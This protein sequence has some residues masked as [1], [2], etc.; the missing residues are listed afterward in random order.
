VTYSGGAGSTA[1]GFTAAVSYNGGYPPIFGSLFHS[2]NIWSFSNAVTATTQYTYS[3]ILLMLDTS[4]SMLIG[5]TSSDVT[6]LD[7]YSVCMKTGYLANSSGLNPLNFGGLGVIYEYQA[8]DNDQVDFT[9]VANYVDP[10]GTASDTSGTCAAGYRDTN[11]VVGGQTYSGAPLVP[12]ALACHT[13]TAKAADGYYADLYGNA[14][15]L[16]ATLRLDVVFSATEQVIND[17]ISATQIAGH[18]SVGVYQ[19]NADVAAIAKG[20]GGDPLPEATTNLQTALSEVQADDYNK[21]PGETAIPVLIGSIYTGVT[22]Q[23]VNDGNTNLALSLT[24]WLNGNASG[25]AAISASGSGITAATPKKFMFLV[26]DGLEDS[27]PG[28]LGGVNGQRVMGEMTGVLAESA[29]TGVC[30]QLKSLGFTVYV[31]YVPYTPVPHITF[32]T[33]AYDPQTDPYT[34]TDYPAVTNG[35]EQEMVEGT[36]ATNGTAPDLAALKACASS[37]NDFFEADQSSQISTALQQ[38]MTQAMPSTTRVTQ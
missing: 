20:G 35:D 15:R 26:T 38:M 36:G 32:Y 5:A 17:M 14:R 27:G 3:E 33:A 16:G 1:P 8:G 7:E 25:G 19:F 22:T 24:D 34:N 18:M 29:G 6:T 10:S 28:N 37:T 12:C 30:S 31:L 23:E 11:I 4:N 9:K 13:T 21:T 2:T